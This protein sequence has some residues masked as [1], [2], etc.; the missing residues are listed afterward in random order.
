MS[1]Q[2]LSEQEVIANSVAGL[3]LF[4]GDG[5]I[6]PAVKFNIVDPVSSATGD[7]Q[8]QF[9]DMARNMRYASWLGLPVLQP[10]PPKSVGK[11]IIVAAGPSIT[12]QLTKIR[13]LAGDPLNAVFAVNW[14]HT[15]LINNGIVPHGCLLFEV[16]AEPVALMETLHQDVTYYVCSHCNV[17]TFKALKD[18]KVVL[19]HN[20]PEDPL[21]QD[22]LSACF[23]GQICLGGGYVTFLRT[24]S[25]AMVLGYRDFDVFGVDSSYPVDSTST[26]VEGYPAGVT[27][28]VDGMD[29]FAQDPHSGEVRAFRSV[30][31]LARQVEEFHNYCA[32]N[33][34]MFRMRLHGD[35]L[36]Q[37]E[38][39]V[40]HPG[41]YGTR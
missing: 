8:P 7:R 2:L 27:D 33:H 13:E 22:A 36:L 28:R 6:K 30:P 32:V 29:I 11:G 34:A 9:A 1:D 19:W 3:Q 24:I 23:R 38:H 16:D 40:T 12:S 39:R 31:Y 20:N 15:W 26:H 21:T 37:W 25:L 10:L 5:E 14:A 35:G 18:H 17:G 4:T 41:E